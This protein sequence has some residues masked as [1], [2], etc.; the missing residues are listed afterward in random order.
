MGSGV[1]FGGFV[2]LR[3]GVRLRSR[4]GDSVGASVGGA[5]GQGIGWP[6]WSRTGVPSGFSWTPP[7]GQSVLGGGWAGGQGIGWP[8]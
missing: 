7:G 5:A 4:L 3:R 2:G 8:F 1:G 6:F